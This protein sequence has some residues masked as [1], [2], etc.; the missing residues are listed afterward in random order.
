MTDDTD[1]TT[2]DLET[3][4]TNDQACVP[5]TDS[6]PVDRASTDGGEV[7]ATPADEASRPDASTGLSWEDVRRKL[8]LA[9]IAVLAL[10]ATWATFQVYVSTSQAIGIWLSDAYVPIFRAGFNVVV[11][12]VALAG[13]L[14]LVRELS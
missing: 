6:A 5:S 9:A 1:R 10:L 14:A 4:R 7:E 13:I 8:L 11:V 2:T 12:L 3:D